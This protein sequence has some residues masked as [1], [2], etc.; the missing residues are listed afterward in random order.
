MGTEA[1][2]ASAATPLAEPCDVA[3]YSAFYLSTFRS[4]AKFVLMAG[5]S[6][7][8]AEDAVQVAMTDLYLRWGQVHK[9]VA[10]VRRAAINA[11]I[12]AKKKERRDRVREFR[13]TSLNMSADMPPDGC[14][15]R[16]LAMWEN[17]QEVQRLLNAL[18]QAQREVM[19]FIIDNY[20]P[21]EIAGIFG[22]TA[23]TVRQNLKAARTRLKTELEAKRAAEIHQPYGKHPIWEGAQHERRHP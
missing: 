11:F 9:P 4:V 7:E 20:T 10:Y 5:A 8:E 18:P 23:A 22:K 14:P 3:N 2:A 12:K 15:D 1:W 21:A 13:Y 6:L 19:S 16:Q 17:G